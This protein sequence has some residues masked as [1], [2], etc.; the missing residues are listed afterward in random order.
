MA[1]EAPLPERCPKCGALYAI[2]GTAHRCGGGSNKEPPASAAAAPAAEVLAS[3]R[4]RDVE[5][6][7]LYMRDY[8]RRYRERV[9]N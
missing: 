9:R 4:Y 3:Y 2:V 6:R 7:R 5:R 1:N 8:M